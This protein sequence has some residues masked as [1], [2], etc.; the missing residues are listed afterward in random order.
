MLF[1]FLIKNSSLNNLQLDATDQWGKASSH[2]SVCFHTHLSAFPM[3]HF[4]SVKHELQ[5][6]CFDKL[7]SAG[8]HRVVKVQPAKVRFS[9]LGLLPI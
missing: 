1:F 3:Q 9:P 2:F 5:P 6:Y 4:P 8:W 7:S